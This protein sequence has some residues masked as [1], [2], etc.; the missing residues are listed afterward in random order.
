MPICW[1]RF[2]KHLL[3]AK[4]PSVGQHNWDYHAGKHVN[5]GRKILVSIVIVILPVINWHSYCDQF[6]PLHGGIITLQTL[7]YS[8]Q[9][10]CQAL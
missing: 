5:L 8:L 6:I 9:T 2:V 7:L 3:A 4:A 1:A 10:S